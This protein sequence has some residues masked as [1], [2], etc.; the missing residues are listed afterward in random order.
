MNKLSKIV[1][2]QDVDFKLTPS[3]SNETSIN[4]STEIS[5]FISD[6]SGEIAFRIFKQDLILALSYVC[7]LLPLYYKKETSPANLLNI[8]PKLLSQIQ[9]EFGDNDSVI[10]SVGHLKRDDGRNYLNGLKLSNGFTLRSFLIE[11]HT[12]LDFCKDDDGQLSIRVVTSPEELDAPIDVE[13]ISVPPAKL[14][15][16]CSRYS[17]PANSGWNC[18]SS[19]NAF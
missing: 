9:S 16:R 11:K 6:E 19:F 8:Y 1:S 7:I 3:S 4:L 14:D 15:D 5:N 13:E 2:R 18:A 12:Q 10:Y 17:L